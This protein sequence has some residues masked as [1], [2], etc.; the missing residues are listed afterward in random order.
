VCKTPPSFARVVRTELRE[1]PTRARVDDRTS[2]FLSFLAKNRGE[3][4]AKD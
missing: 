3:L 4:A 1:R 2:F